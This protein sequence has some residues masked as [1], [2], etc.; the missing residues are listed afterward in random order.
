M[1]KQSIFQPWLL[2]LK[3][4]LFSLLEITKRILAASLEWV[5]VSVIV[6]SFHQLIIKVQSFPILRWN[7]KTHTYSH[8]YERH[9]KLFLGRSLNH[10]CENTFCRI[11]R[12]SKL[13]QSHASL[14]KQRHLATY[15]PLA[16]ILS[17][18]I[19]SSYLLL[20]NLRG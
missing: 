1:K 5:D 17:Y 10:A 13:Q 15:S 6:R 8:H 14:R 16:I 2:C 7:Q 20:G 12:W 19:L 11:L 9:S 4:L 3:C 18:Q